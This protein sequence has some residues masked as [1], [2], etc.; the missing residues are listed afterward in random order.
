ML[1]GVLIRRVQDRSF[2]EQIAQGAALLFLL[3]LNTS[4]AE[5]CYAAPLSNSAFD[6]PLILAACETTIGVYCILLT[7]L[8]VDCDGGCVNGENWGDLLTA[9][10]AVDFLWAMLAGPNEGRREVDARFRKALKEALA[11]GRLPRIQP[12]PS[13]GGQLFERGALLSLARDKWPEKMAGV[14]APFTATSQSM[15]GLAYRCRRL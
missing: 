15:L 3:A 2:E 4:G 8:E 7:L 6:N 14:S 5:C 10:Q 9:K 12:V 11:I 13:V 1:G